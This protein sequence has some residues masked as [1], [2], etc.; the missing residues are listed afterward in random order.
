[1]PIVGT[2]DLV[3]H[4]KGKTA[5]EAS[6]V[7]ENLQLTGI[8][9]KLEVHANNHDNYVI[10]YSINEW[11]WIAILRVYQTGHITFYKDEVDI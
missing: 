4:F 3:K 11:D 1:M 5:K 10:G 2:E 7:I 9:L 6:Q 8:C